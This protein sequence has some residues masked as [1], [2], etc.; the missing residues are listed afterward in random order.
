M[1]FVA[2]VLFRTLLPCYNRR[3]PANC[4]F[5]FI[6][7]RTM[8]AIYHN[9][10]CSKSRAAL[11]LAEEFAASENLPLTIIDYLK[12]PP[13]LPQLVELHRQLGTDACQMVR[14]NEEEFASLDS[15][16]ADDG[17]WLAAIAD[18]PKLLQR[19]IVVYRDR[20]LICRPPELLIDFLRAG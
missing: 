15:L 12:A 14:E 4:G 20:A 19:P 9:P 16:P 6:Q 2:A 17:A 13:T 18:N 10:R 8:I 5:A 7:A 1:H 3:P 11:A